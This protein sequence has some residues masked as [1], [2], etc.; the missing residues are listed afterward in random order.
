MLMLL[1]FLLCKHCVFFLY[2]FFPQAS[3]K[4][5]LKPSGFH[6]YSPWISQQCC[7]WVHSTGS[8]LYQGPARKHLPYWN[9]PRRALPA[10]GKWEGT[11]KW[12]LENCPEIE[13]L[14][15]KWDTHQANLLK[16][17]CRRR[18]KEKWSIRRTGFSYLCGWHVLLALDVK[19]TLDVVHVGLH[20]L[21]S[22]RHSSLLVAVV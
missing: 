1:R 4:Y 6:L 7:S 15:Q 12:G 14:V 19:K 21:K 8:A 2:Y 16:N 13:V 11:L 20:V 3:K 18:G 22:W 9:C 17:E 10:T 5:H